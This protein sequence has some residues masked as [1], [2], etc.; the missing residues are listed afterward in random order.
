MLTGKQ[1]IGKLEAARAAL[2]CL[3]PAF[4]A[5]D[6][7]DAS[8]FTASL[9]DD[10]SCLVAHDYFRKRSAKMAGPV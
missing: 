3:H 4:V 9:W 1:G 5:A 6:P 2:S 8:A 10:P 7:S